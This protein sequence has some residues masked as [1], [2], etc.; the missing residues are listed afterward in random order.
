MPYTIGRHADN[1]LVIRDNRASRSHARILKEGDD[2][3][4]EDLNSR[5]GVFVNGQRVTRQR[6]SNSDRIDF[7]FHDS[8]KLIFSLE[9]DELHKLM[10]Q[11]SPPI[12]SLSAP[13]GN[14][15]RLRALVEVARALQSSLST[16]DVLIAVVDAALAVTGTERGF[17]LLRKED[18][19]EVSVARDRHGGPLANTDLKVPTT[20]INRALAPAGNCSR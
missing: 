16:N 8:Y 10:D 19:L 3:V 4:L 20:L 17:L 2:Y 1:V 6:L 9:A 18:H 13:G 12:S 5:H 15:A 14:L 7:G 11:I